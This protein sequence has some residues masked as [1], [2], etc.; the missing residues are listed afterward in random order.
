[1]AATYEYSLLNLGNVLIFLFRQSQDGYVFAFL[2]GNSI[3]NG[4]ITTEKTAARQIKS[5]GR[6]S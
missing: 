6:Y 2:A 5:K 4:N 3:T 1:M